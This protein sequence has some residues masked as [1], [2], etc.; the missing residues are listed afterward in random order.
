MI[1]EMVDNNSEVIKVHFLKYIELLSRDKV[2][3]VQI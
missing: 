3:N 1:T 2:V